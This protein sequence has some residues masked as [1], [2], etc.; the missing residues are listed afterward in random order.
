MHPRRPENPTSSFLVRNYSR[1]TEPILVGTS[2][3]LGFQEP[4]DTPVPYFLPGT[5]AVSYFPPETLALDVF[6]S[7]RSL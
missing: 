5:L 4:K 7:H 2:L 1:R 3:L 6:F